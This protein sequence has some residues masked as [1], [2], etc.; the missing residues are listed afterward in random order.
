[1]YEIHQE[2]PVFNL[3]TELLP[4]LVEIITFF[5]KVMKLQLNKNYIILTYSVITSSKLIIKTL[6]QR[7]RICSKLTIKE[8]Q[9]H[10]LCRSGGFIVN[11]EQVNTHK[12][13]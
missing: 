1:M 7:C 2:V 13:F 9:R 8:L 3:T 5:G 12:N 4:D 10:F 11:F 6:E